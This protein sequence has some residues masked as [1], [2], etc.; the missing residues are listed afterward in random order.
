M[1][2]SP[3]RE[4]PTPIRLAQIVTVP[5]TFALLE[6]QTRYM[7]ERGFEI[8]GISSAGPYQT[9]FAAR[10]LV[11]LITVE[12]PRRITPFQDLRAIA[13][14]V[15]TLLAIQPHIVHAHTPKGGLL[16]M[17]AATI[18]RVP[19][20]IYHM[21]GL[22]LM[23]ATGFRRRLLR[24]SERTSCGLA[25]RVLCVSHSLRRYAV[26]EGLCTADKIVTPLGG[27]GNGIDA[28]GRFHPDLP[29]DDAAERRREMRERC[30]IPE[31][32]IVIAF[33]GRL[34]RDKGLIELAEAWRT[35]SARCPS[36]HLLIAGPYEPQDP[37]PEATRRTL[38]LDP[39]VHLLGQTDDARGVYAAA[40]IVTLPTYRE[41]MPNVPLE[42]AAMR[43]PV[44]AT[45]IPGCVDAVQDGV[46]G[47]LVPPADADALARALDTYVRDA[48]LRVRHGRAGRD[49]ILREFDRE[50][51]WAATHEQYVELLR[52][53]I[54][55]LNQLPGESAARRLVHGNAAGAP[56]IGGA[57]KRSFDVVVSAIFLILLSPL[58][59]VV[60]LV[61]RYTMS[62]PVLFRQSRPGLHERPFAM[63]KFRTMREPRAGEVRELSDG[64]RL[65]R[66]G[67]FM[68]RTSVDELP[69]LW[70]VLR[71]DMS[72]VGP[73]PLLQQYLPYFTER[74]RIRF[75]VRP[76]ITGLAQ[77]RGR[78]RAS[79]DARLALDV[80]YVKTQSLLTDM[81]ILFATVRAVFGGDGVAVDARA[82]MRNFDEE[83]RHR[84]SGHR[85]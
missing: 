23:T 11:R 47:T 75:A 19:V 31:D 40:D 12:M 65:T 60:A 81:R 26:D 42:A 3:V 69:E 43:L 61:V 25:H 22:P 68:R 36:L 41:G 85:L 39:R 38:E 54:P 21:R 73:R 28:F 30:G 83:R 10:E 64:S 37:V 27:S 34:V 78:N 56:M 29:A 24:W 5:Q 8:T 32:A 72:L 71:G 15:K 66:I 51:I 74:E 53:H 48:E 77:V 52:R 55:G 1:N 59:L 80:E 35:L 44:V 17:I 49:W 79:W 13:Q 6:G 14:L 82:I 50:H 84:L 2:D 63:V 76:G 58:L 67:A 45:R 57:I 62:S 33:L 20:R 7:A 16:G 46:T 18:A 9:G 4:H 70:N